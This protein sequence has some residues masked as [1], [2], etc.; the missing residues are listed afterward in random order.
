VKW[1][2]EDAADAGFRTYFIWDLTRPVDPGSDSRVR[3]ELERRGVTILDSSS[4]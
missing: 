3:D 4:L 2:A 1:T